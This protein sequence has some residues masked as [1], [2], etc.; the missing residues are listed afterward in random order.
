ME[1][2]SL[3]SSTFLA[4]RIS[5]RIAVRNSSELI[6]PVHL[7]LAILSLIDGILWLDDWELSPYE[8]T[9]KEIRAN[10]TNRLANLKINPFELT[11]QRRRIEKQLDIDTAF[12]GNL[13]LHRGDETHK[14]FMNAMYNSDKVGRK[15]V[16][17]FDL[18]HE[19]SDDSVQNSIVSINRNK[20]LDKNPNKQSKLKEELIA[21]QIIPKQRIGNQK[22]SELDKLGIDLTQRAQEHRITPII[23]REKEIKAIIRAFQRTTKRNVILIGEA[24]VGKTSVVEG[25]AQLISS[26]DAPEE[27]RQLRVVQI[28]I[29]DLIAGTQYR[30]ALEERLLK[31]MEEV[32][33]N[34]NLILFLDEIHLVVGAGKVEGGAIDIANILKPALAR[35]DFHCIG[36]TTSDEYE[37]NIKKDPAFQRRFQVINIPEPNE[38]GKLAIGKAWIERIE[39]LQGIKFEPDVLESAIGL[40]DQYIR[41]RCQPDKVIDLLENVAAYVKVRSLFSDKENKPEEVPFVTT[42]DLFEILEEHY[43]I[44]TEALPS[45]K[46]DALEDFLFK[47][48]IGQDEAIKTISETVTSLSVL[49]HR[50]K[51]RVKG[52]L[53]FIGPTGVGKSYSAQL[54]ASYLFPDNHTAFLRISM[55]EY[56]ERYYLSRLIGSSP[57]LIGHETAGLFFLFAEKNPQGVILLDEFDKAHE[58]IQDYFLQI[59]D[60]GEARNNRGRLVDFRGHLFIMTSNLSS[61]ERI[62]IQT[63]DLQREKLV[64]HFRPEFLSRLDQVVTFKQFSNDNYYE[65]FDRLIKNLSVEI[66]PNEIEFI[67]DDTAKLNI[68]FS[69]VYQDEGAR[70]FIRNFEQQI[71]IPT[72]KLLTKEP[73]VKRINLFYSQ[74][75]IILQP[76]ESI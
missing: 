2:V 4:W 46:E 1:T 21:H 69:L 27:L 18:L 44:R 62:E 19:I 36:A 72:I 38:T 24:G 74:D 7:L 39:K 55:N 28:N 73:N 13:S 40:T 35:N 71:F 50:R 20:S 54:I 22:T 33:S 53:L 9:I 56:K 32:S 37:S 3:D 76:T 17:V 41:D 10:K 15:S 30:G 66:H 14:I 16:D 60:I 48:L 52:V 58:E 31:L 49:S 57:G 43:G 26:D 51:D 47:Q 42:K 75:Q 45:L 63:P 5:N 12:D 34:P 11:K 61:E 68:I 67:M 25:L 8:E 23:G 59:F 64:K 70:G 29:A 65:L 6:E